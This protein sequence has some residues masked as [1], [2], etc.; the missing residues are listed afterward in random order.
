[1]NARLSHVSWLILQTAIVAG[2]VIADQMSPDR[3]P[4]MFPL[5]TG[6][7]VAALV[8]GISIRLTD[9]AKRLWWRTTASRAVRQR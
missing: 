9:W 2:I 5:V 8:T 3:G 1:M 7:A 6:I 4:I